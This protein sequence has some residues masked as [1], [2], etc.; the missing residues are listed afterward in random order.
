MLHVVHHPAYVSPATP[1]SRFRFDKYGL[2]MEALRESAPPMTLHTPDPMPRAWIEAVHDPDYVEEV[3]SLTVP[4]SKER[5]IGFPVTERVM[6][7]SLLSPG[8][9]WAAARLARLHGFAANAAGGSH[10]ALA[11]SGAGYCVFNDLAI[12][13]NRL[14]A[15]GEA[16]RILILDLDVHQGDGTASLLAGRSDIFTLSIHADKNFPVRKA[17]STLDIGLPDGVEDAAYLTIL[18]DTLPRV[19]DDFAP[20]LILYQAGVDP[21]GDDRLGRLALTDAGLDARDRY[22]IRQARARAIP[23]ASTMGGG[24]GEDRMAVAHRHAACMIRMAQEIL[25]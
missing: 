16:D 2:V 11:D 7:R 25:G 17:R 19:L 3:L 13:A 8:G 21:H 1:G 12:A 15:E 24:Y 5:R 6:R 14:I 22:V 20:D 9:T 18:H 10:H 4:P 23:V